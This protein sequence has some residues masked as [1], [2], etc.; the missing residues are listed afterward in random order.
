MISKSSFAT[1]RQTLPLR[2]GWPTPPAEIRHCSHQRAIKPSSMTI[3]SSVKMAKEFTSSPITI[4]TCGESHTLSWRVEEFQVSPDGKTLAYIRNEDG[5][6]RLHLLG[7]VA[8]KERSAPQ[9][10][11]GIISDLKW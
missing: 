10:P 2:C 3:R 6:S 5:I 1:S 11:I 8:G 4:L 7:V 9:L